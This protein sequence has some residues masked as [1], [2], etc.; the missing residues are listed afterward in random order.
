MITSA[1][2]FVRLRTSEVPEEYRRAA[3][4]PAPLDVWLQVVATHP[5]MRFWVAQNKTVPRSVLELLA[6]DPDVRV[7][8]MVARKRSA[9]YALLLRLAAD[10]Q[11]SVRRAVAGNPKAPAAVLAQLRLDPDDGVARAADRPLTEPPA[12]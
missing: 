3:H 4:E 2:E 12:D 10:R 5:E 11:P 9:G 6:A 8:E 7:R 1:E